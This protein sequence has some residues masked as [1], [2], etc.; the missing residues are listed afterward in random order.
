M[1]LTQALGDAAK[2]HHSANVVIGQER[3]QRVVGNFGIDS[4]GVGEWLARS[5]GSGS[6]RGGELEHHV[7]GRNGFFLDREGEADLYLVDGMHDWCN[8]LRAPNVDERTTKVKVEVRRLDD[9]LEGM[10]W[11]RV[12]FIKLDVEGAELS[13]LQGARKMLRS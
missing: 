1:S 10:S 13:F 4:H 12:D 5:G 3:G 7:L 8:S 11:P 6:E 2:R 9:V